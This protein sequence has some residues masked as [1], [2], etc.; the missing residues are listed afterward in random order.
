MNKNTPEELA[1][2]LKVS[3]SIWQASY[4]S[5]GRGGLKMDDFTL[6]LILFAT[7]VVVFAVGVGVGQ[8][9]L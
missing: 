9:F 6:L 4:K 8:H 1:E 5:M 2:L 7:M 3:A